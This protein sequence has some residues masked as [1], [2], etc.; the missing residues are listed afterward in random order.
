[1]GTIDS[2]LARTVSGPPG[3]GIAFVLDLGGVLRRAIRR[4]P[5]G[6]PSR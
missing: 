3:R 6:P 4:R 1:M 5:G 2:A